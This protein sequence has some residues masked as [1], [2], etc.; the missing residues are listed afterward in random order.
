MDCNSLFAVQ[1]QRL[2][3]TAQQVSLG[4][5]LDDGL[6]SATDSYAWHDREEKWEDYWPMV[7]LMR[8]TL[9]FN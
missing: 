8:E 2:M 3:A 5:Y 7:D 4:F 9:R 6:Y 1:A